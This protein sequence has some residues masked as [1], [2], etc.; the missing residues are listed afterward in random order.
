MAMTD[1]SP[2]YKRRSPPAK[3]RLRGVARHQSFLD[4]ARVIALE[5]GLNAVTMESVA[6]RAGVTKALGYRFFENREALLQALFDHDAL[7][8]RSTI[9]EIVD[10]NASFEDQLRQVF[11]A[12]VHI[13]MEHR[14][15]IIASM[16]N[17]PSVRERVKVEDAVSTEWLSRQIIRGYGA[18]RAAARR[19]ARV[20]LGLIPAMVRG[21]EAGDGSPEE[22]VE[23]AV[24]AFVAAVRS[25]APAIR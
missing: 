18:E 8:F 7:I 14:S 25:L 20:L 22:M 23:T 4:A 9:R 5:G 24:C 21:V 19:M 16:Y 13:S 6:H 11:R 1:L 2:G 10:R 12:I 3:S 17:D 15:V